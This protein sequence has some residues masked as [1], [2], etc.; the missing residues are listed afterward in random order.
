MKNKFYGYYKPSKET[1]DSLWDNALI[2]LDANILLD[3]Y[4]LSKSTCDDLFEVLKTLEDRIWI[5]YQA[6]NE[7]H[8]N[9]VNVVKSQIKQNDEALQALYAFKKFF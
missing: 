6:A 3:F 5:P 1:F 7:Y 4:R 9:I 8:K 2:V